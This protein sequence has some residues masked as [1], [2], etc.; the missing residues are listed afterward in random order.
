M[1][2]NLGQGIAHA[3]GSLGKGHGQGL[4]AWAR[5]QGL[6][7]PMRAGR[8]VTTCRQI[9]TNYYKLTTNCQQIVTK[10]LTELLQIGNKLLTNCILGSPGGLPGS[11]GG[12]YAVLTRPH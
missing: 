3:L 5:D 12:G 10:L 8:F 7:T 11:P 2:A 6:T 1:S 9:A 4:E